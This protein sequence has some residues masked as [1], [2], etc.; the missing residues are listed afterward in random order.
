MAERLT[1]ALSPYLEQ[2]ADNPVD[3]HPWGPAALEAA[4]A[5]DRP[6]LLSIGYAACHWCH[7][8]ARESFA[9]EAIARR[10]NAWFVSI[11]VDR[12]ERPDLDRV[13]QLA[14]QLLTG[15]PGGW[16]L[17]VFLD[18]RDLMPIVAGTYFPPEARHGL[19]GFGELLERV[20]IA[21][22][23]QRA[24]LDGQS[25]QLRQALEMI[26][27]RRADDDTPEEDP[28][29]VL[30]NQLSARFDAR[31]GGFGAAPRFP[32][33]ALLDCLLQIAVDDDG[34]A[35]LLIDTLRPMVRYGLQ[36]HLGGGFFRYCVD[37]AWE[38]PHFE[39]MLADN[40]ALLPVLAEAA[41]RWD[42]RELGVAAEGIVA[43]L[44]RDMALPGGGLATSLDADSLP[45]ADAAEAQ[46]DAPVEGAF[47]RWT[48]AQFR[49]ALDASLH[50]LAAARFGLDGPA[51][52]HG[53]DWHL[54]AARSLDEL[55]ATHGD[56]QAVQRQLDQARVQLLQARVQRPAPA[57]DDKLLAGLNALA[58]SG[59]VR[60]GRAL[61][62][63]DWLD[64]AAD[65]HAAILARPFAAT[66]AAAVWRD[67]RTGQ[68]ALLEDHAAVLVAT[69]DLLQW[70]WSDTALDLCHGLVET[71]LTRFRDRHDGSFYLTPADHEAMIL[72]P[73]AA[74]DDATPSGAALAVSGLLE[75]AHLT[76]ND[77]AL[78]AAQ[79][80]LRAAAG[81]LER[82]PIAH[83]GL[84]LAA[85]RHAAPAPQ[86][87]IGGAGP[88]ADAWHA[89]LLARPELRVYRIAPGNSGLP[90]PLAA[91]AGFE[92]PRAV[93]C[94]GRHC[95]E[96]LDDFAS[97]EQALERS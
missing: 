69:L 79:A 27:R 57:R 20:H 30:V 37:S 75:Y 29:S 32:Q 95:V 77:D 12:E 14:H 6:I 81:E 46:A 23:R 39:K 36:D 1:G 50:D 85:R 74:S 18:P 58:V 55:V 44:Q 53:R 35:Q 54:I 56:R 48:R 96:P 24:E 78:Q 76:G 17:T 38:I 82:A 25:R 60:A 47:Y 93:V 64:Q 4:R 3:W 49:A 43:F 88:A 19:I 84:I 40:V 90:G 62:R 67:G 34:A 94:R 89:R 10:L 22:D 92:A 42:D 2:H 33:A 70:R 21:W 61:A 11:K 28:G 15:R 45:A 63:N 91:V 31:H 8:M 73:P 65:L 80:A 52:F 7:V 86:V 5:A 72:R 26:T 16:P 83:A 13:Y 66:P 87:L 97:L 59:L 71:L 9:D 51:N 68:H 41:R